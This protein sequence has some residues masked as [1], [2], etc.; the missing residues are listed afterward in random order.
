CHSGEAKKLKANLYLDSRDGFVTGGDKGPAIVPGK[1]E[2]SLLIEAMHYVNVDLQ[3]PPKDKLDTRVVADFE[4]WIAWGAPWPAGEKK[5]SHGNSAAA[6]DLAKRKAEHWAWQPVVNS[7]V[8]DLADNDWS[9]DPID[10]FVL[11]KLREN[12]LQPGVPA[13]KRTLIRR[14]TF[15]LTGLPPTPEDVEAFVSN[16]SKDAYG[17][18]VDRLLNSPRFGERWARHWLDLVRYAE[19]R[20]HEFDY[21][22]PNA[23]R[24][25]DYVIRAF[26]ADLPYNAFVTEHLAGDLLPEPRLHPEEKFNESVIGTGFWFLGECLH[27][28][29]DIKQDEA[30]RFD[31]MV[32]VASKSFLSLTVACARCHDHK[33]DAISTKDYYSMY[34]FLQSSNYHQA[35]IDSME[36]NRVI[37]QELRG[38]SDAAKRDLANAYVETLKPAIAATA[39]YLQAA[40]EPA[41]ETTASLDPVQL[42]QW[43]EALAS[44]KDLLQSVSPSHA[45]EWAAAQ[46]TRANEQRDG[47][48]TLSV[49]ADYA[50]IGQPQFIQD[51]GQGFGLAPVRPGSIR[52]GDDG[53]SGIETYGAARRDPLWSDLEI[54]DSDRDPASQTSQQPGRML[55]SPTFVLQ[56]PGKI[57][58]LVKGKG[59]AMA[60]VDSHR[61]VQGPLHGNVHRKLNGQDG[62]RWEEHGLERYIGHTLHIE[63]VP[64]GDSPFEVLVIAQAASASVTLPDVDL[65]EN[66]PL[67][68]LANSCSN[69]AAPVPAFVA[70]LLT[71]LENW[72]TGAATGS[73]LAAEDAR[74]V[75]WLVSN[76]HLF[77]TDPD[78]ALAQARTIARRYLSDQ[79]AITAKRVQKTRTALAIMDGTPVDDVVYIR[80]SYKSP[81]DTVPRRFLEALGGKEVAPPA[82][83]SGRL[84]LAQQ[85]TDPRNPLVSRSIVNRLWHHLFGQGIVPTTDDFGVLGQRPSHPE[86]LDHLAHAF[87]ADGWSIKRQIKRIVMSKT[88][89][90]ASTA[91]HPAA[92]TA[93]PENKWLH[94]A[95]VRRLQSEAIRDALLAVSGRLDTTSF[96]RSV[97][98]HLTDFMTGR[99]RPGNSGPLDGNGRRS[100]YLEVRRNFLNPMMLTF[101]TPI[102][103]NAMG[104]RSVS[105]V[106]SQAL[107]LMNDPFVVQQADVWA[108]RILGLPELTLTDRINRMY[109]EAFARP[110]SVEE[111]ADAQTFIT[112]HADEMN[113]AV[114]S[115]EV[116]ADFAHVLFNTKEFIFLD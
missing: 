34:G 6:F 58:Y 102:P 70:F 105:N 18:L 85:V 112:Q 19:T 39:E 61:L 109:Q 78:T 13:D 56:A 100:V 7:T 31:N 11:E 46:Q 110:A 108:S 113:L 62:L 79:S 99:G 93:D 32:D 72:R 114:T 63:V 73:A 10:K 30:D 94:R 33:F 1:P 71:A 90:L 53:I 23:F 25:R 55:R 48:R 51:G 5:A 8:P 101:D 65:F 49:V 36:P 64:E 47:W 15:D 40:L 42:Q 28:P 38:R 27:S 87:V 106:P 111:I 75:N 96:G 9:Q 21:T 29:V 35:P 16:V 50:T 43:K 74:A 89:Q 83:G 54:V 59:T 91:T 98:V 103:F 14:L 82:H 76:Q 2:Q 104:R 84:E 44:P 22:V 81:G 3:M 107:I 37:A 97:P 92:E 69:A 67:A 68:S 52:I 12:N 20:G 17:E 60:V 80:G 88:Y 57:Y 95:N 86:L 41:E 66:P 26:N 4:K 115:P 116:W 45:G 77:L 24:Y